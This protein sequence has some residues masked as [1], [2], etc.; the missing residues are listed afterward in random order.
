MFWF[1]TTTLAVKKV[2]GV[3]DSLV[4]GDPCLASSLWA[5]M[6]PE[7]QQKFNQAASAQG[8]KGPPQQITTLE[9]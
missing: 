2:V 3:L 4:M 6:A 5:E 7:S 9:D 8:L 1:F